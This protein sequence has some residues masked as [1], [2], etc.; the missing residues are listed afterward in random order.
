MNN[1]LIPANS[2]K[3]MLK[4]GLFNKLDLIIFGIGIATTL[5]CLI[6]FQDFVSGSF[7]I[8]ILTLLPALIT[9]FLVMPVPN[10]HNIRTLLSSVFKFIMGQRKFKWK[11]WCVPHGEDK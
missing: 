10:Y 1:Y 7:V 2:K 4:F 5:L 8:A 11:G 6:V 9:G 3:S